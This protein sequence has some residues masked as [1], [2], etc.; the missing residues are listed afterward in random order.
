MAFTTGDNNFGTAK[1]IVD[2][3]AGQGTHTT[4]TAALSAASSGDDIFIRPGT[5]TENLTL[6]A[7]V[8]L[9][10]FSGDD[11]TPNVTI[12]GKCS[13][14]AAGTTTI[15][16]IRLKTNGDFCISVTGSAASIL[17]LYE[18]T[19]EASNNTAIQFTSSSSSSMIEAFTCN[20]LIDTTGIAFFSHSSAGVLDFDY[21]HLL[22]AG[23]STTN[24]TCSAGQLNIRWSGVQFPV[25]CSGTSIFSFGYSSISPAGINTIAF[26]TSGTS[27]GQAIDCDFESGT[28]SAISVGVG[29]TVRLLGMSTVSSSNTNAITGAGSLQYSTINFTSSSATINTTSVAAISTS[30]PTISASG[31]ASAITLDSSGNVTVPNGTFYVDRATGE[32]SIYAN[33][34]Q[35]SAGAHANV[36]TQSQAGGGDSFLRMQVIGTIDW[37]V[38]VANSGLLNIGFGG[39]PSGLAQTIMSMTPVLVANQ[40]EVAFPNA[41]WVTMAN[42]PSFSAY[43]SSARAN[44]TGDGTVYTLIFNTEEYDRGG[45]FDGTSTF[46]APVAG[47]YSF[48]CRVLLT[49][50]GA[51][52]TS[53]QINLTKTG[54]TTYYGD[55]YNVAAMRTSSNIATLA[56]SKRISLTAG[57][58]VTATVAVSG[59][60]K[61]VGID[62]S[63][64]ITY[65]DATLDC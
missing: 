15:S 14:T 28:A 23:S 56:I 32:A 43:N 54:I 44:E 33:A 49:N 25:T 62:G 57:Q 4:I 42:Q 35:V 65:F 13:F 41:R 8:N 46:T 59:G 39:P 55:T 63:A 36:Y 19:I 11:D 5:Y 22:N 21:C 31:G 38:G 29:S 27:T 6:K 24:S 40:T 51:G 12:V 2:A 48:N 50:L 10:A 52:H 37:T 16:N 17:N 34:N 47:I 61:T 45:V 18:C 7:G 26:T 64:V 20:G 30:I 60:A 9:V 58:T 53:G 1:W 3:T